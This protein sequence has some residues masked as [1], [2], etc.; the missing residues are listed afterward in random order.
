MKHAL[1][2]GLALLAAACAAEG[3][4]QP[5]LLR[6]PSALGRR[7]QELEGQG[8]FAFLA[9][10]SLLAGRGGTI[11]R[12]DWPSARPRGTWLDSGALRAGRLLASSA[13]RTR[14]A[15]ALDQPEEVR[16]LDAEAHELLRLAL[17]GDA[18][19]ALA[20][21]PDGS[22]LAVGTVHGALWIAEL[23]AAQARP[24]LLP[25][26]PAD[27]PGPLTFVGFAGP[28]VLLESGRDGPL[29]ARD[30]RQ[31]TILWTRAAERGLALDAAGGRLLV[32]RVED[33]AVELLALAGRTPPGTAE[34]L[35]S[36]GKPT[37]GRRAAFLGADVA[38]FT[39]PQSVA[40]VGWQDLCFFDL[41][42]ERARGRLRLGAPSALALDPDGR[43]LLVAEGR[44]VLAYELRQVLDAR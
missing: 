26:A 30:A 42:H 31:G 21:T 39:D 15:L 4:A 43:S 27:P 14:V 40:L 41:A 8:S 23:G 7:S 19:S 17:D 37:D 44:R 22:R 24:R 36:A 32:E 25:R 6:E 3:P 28:E 9:D 34:T 18:A 10:G 13:E 38:A 12:F 35:A 20:L 11:Q 2:L 5:A 1:A 29:R 33:G 16:V